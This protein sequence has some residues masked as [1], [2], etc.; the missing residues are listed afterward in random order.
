MDKMLAQL[1]ADVVRSAS[2]FVH[3]ALLGHCSEVYL[4]VEAVDEA[5]ESM[6]FAAPGIESRDI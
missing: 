3:L 1:V 2:V 5:S 4:L 6:A